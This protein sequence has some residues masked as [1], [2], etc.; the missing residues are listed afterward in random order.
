MVERRTIMKFSMKRC[1]K[2]LEELDKGTKKK[3]HKKEL[4][5]PQFQ[6]DVENLTG[7]NS[8]IA[9]TP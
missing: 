2:I 9:E 3:N 1:V 8:V 4:H 5:V 6:N 7:S